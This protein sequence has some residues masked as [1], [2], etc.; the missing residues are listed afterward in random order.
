VELTPDQQEL[1]ELATR[2]PNEDIPTAKRVLKALIGADPFWAALESA[3][4]DDEPVTPDDEAALAEA[5][6]EFGRGETTSHE[7]IL[8]EFGIK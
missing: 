6:A 1:V 7:E 5:E 3:P 8:R 4:Y 2:V